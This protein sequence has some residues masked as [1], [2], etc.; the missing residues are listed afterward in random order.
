VYLVNAAED[1]S[2]ILL[3]AAHSSETREGA[4]QLVTVEH[5]KVSKP[6]GQFFP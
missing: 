2:V 5:A 1:M 6:D 4:R 3:E